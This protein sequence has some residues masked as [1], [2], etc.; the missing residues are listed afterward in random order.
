MKFVLTNQIIQMSHN[1]FR[2]GKNEGREARTCPRS[3]ESEMKSDLEFH[4]PDPWCATLYSE[5]FVSHKE[6]WKM[7][8]K[9]TLINQCSGWVGLSIGHAAKSREIVC[10]ID[11]IL[12]C[13][14]FSCIFFRVKPSSWHI[15]TENWGLILTW[16]NCF[17][18]SQRPQSPADLGCVK[19]GHELTV[20][21]STPC[22]WPWP[23][24]A[25]ASCI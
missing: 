2:D 9:K 13:C 1:Y 8:I 10:F 19:D 20:L 11:L 17:R 6:D 12:T 22:M 4:I 3:S 25:L 18:E 21:L 5:C 14:I 16:D 7:L 23:L 15:F 24:S